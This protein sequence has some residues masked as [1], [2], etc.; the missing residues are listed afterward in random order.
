MPAEAIQPQVHNEDVD[1]DENEIP[2]HLFG[3]APE[4]TPEEANKNLREIIRIMEEQS[5]DEG[6]VD[7]S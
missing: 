6:A 2:G 4:I 3:S 1:P 5:A 7:E